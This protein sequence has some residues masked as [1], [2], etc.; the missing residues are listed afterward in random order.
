MRGTSRFEQVALAVLVLT[1][2]V[3][4][5][6]RAPSCAY[7]ID[8]RS[9]IEVASLIADGESF[10]LV[11]PPAG[12]ARA[13]S[14]SGPMLYYALAFF[15]LLGGDALGVYTW[16]APLFALSVWLLWWMLRE[17]TGPTAALMAAALYATSPAVGVEHL[18]AF[19]S[20]LAS[21]L[22]TA[23]G[24]A[25]AHYV[26]RRRPWSLALVLGLLGALLQVNPMSV[27][28]VPL[29]ALAFVLYRPPV[30]RWPV[31]VGL[32]AVGLLY[33]PWIAYQ[34]QVGF[35]DAWRSIAAIGAPSHEAASTPVWR[36]VG[37]ALRAA[38]FLPGDTAGLYPGAHAAW[39][40]PVE[41]AVLVAAL[42]GVGLLVT[43]VVRGNGDVRRSAAL[44]M[45]WLAIPYLLFPLAR[46]GV[47]SYHFY[48][49]LPAWCAAAGAALA[50]I[51]DRNTGPWRVPN[52]AAWAS[53]MSIVAAQAVFDMRIADGAD[54]LGAVRWSRMALLSAP[55][56]LWRD[57]SAQ[58]EFLTVRAANDLIGTVEATGVPPEER[59]R[60]FHGPIYGRLSHLFPWSSTVSS[61]DRETHYALG[62]D[63]LGG[64]FHTAATVRVGP[65]CLGAYRT[66]LSRFESGDADSAGRVHAWAPVSM[67]LVAAAQRPPFVGQSMPAGSE[68]A[69]RAYLSA[70]GAGVVAVS[71]FGPLVLG[72]DATRPRVALWSDGRRVPPAREMRRTTLWGELL[73]IFPLSAERDRPIQLEIRIRGWTPEMAVDLF[74][75]PGLPDADSG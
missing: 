23:W 2:L 74:Q 16:L 10:P 64:C 42:C 1:A 67:P 49:A 39:Y 59:D 73:E 6:H 47:Y 27:L 29:T 28:F 68:R 66:R 22:M 57:P 71:V 17:W 18:I 38:F 61:T 65:Y 41:W 5:A 11:G 12:T 30:R 72:R 21:F 50:W 20:P 55:D 34:V 7:H 58:P 25:L 4:T 9:Q 46:V 40:A 3:S 62:H 32:G 19:A 26:V 37:H 69:L 70:G 52:R 56:P 36:I 53:C 15:H 45:A 43:R 51:A 35:V 48:V 14:L 33:A 60:V 13:G 8:Q 75:Y 24:A 44:V 63:A 31:A 54:R